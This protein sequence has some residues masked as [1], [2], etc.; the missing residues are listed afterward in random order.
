MTALTEQD[1]G[2]IFAKGWS[3]ADFRKAFEA[4]PREA[5]KKYASDL[6][7]DAKAKFS[8]PKKPAHVTADAAKAI[9][10]GSAAPEPMYCC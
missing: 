5:L 7:I 10:E 2:R 1:W 3:D 4:D 9:A 6:N 8:I